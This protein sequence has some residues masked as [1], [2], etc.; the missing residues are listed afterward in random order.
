MSRRNESSLLYLPTTH[1]FGQ[2]NLNSDTRNDYR[3]HQLRDAHNVS[4]ST[5]H[6]HT[7]Y[8]P[9]ERVVESGFSRRKMLTSENSE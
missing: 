6:H 3:L 1:R 2:L 5:K 8:Y 9:T 4:Y 7:S